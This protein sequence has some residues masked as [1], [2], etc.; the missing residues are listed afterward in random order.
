TLA[1]GE[2]IGIGP[3][4]G[5]GRVRF[6]AAS[7]QSRHKGKAP[8][9]VA[10]P[11]IA[12]A[13]AANL[14]GSVPERVKPAASGFAPPDK[15]DNHGSGRYWSDEETQ[16]IRNGYANAVELRDIAVQLVD[17]GYRARSIAAIC[18][19]ARALGCES[20]NPIAK[21]GFSPEEDQILIAAYGDPDI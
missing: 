13:T 5:S 6:K 17:A 15:T 11:K 16:I 8:E 4:L 10:P 7:V 12:A 1:D 21:G 2:F 14:L 18:T 19:R 9:L 3:A 20:Q